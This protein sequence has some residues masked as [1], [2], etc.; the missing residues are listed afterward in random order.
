[1]SQDAVN[2]GQ[3]P[4]QDYI[5]RIAAMVAADLDL[6]TDAPDFGRYKE[7][8]ARALWYAGLH[9]DELMNLGVE[10]ESAPE[11]P[12][13]LAD[14]EWGSIVDL[15]ERQ[16]IAFYWENPRWPWFALS[17]EDWDLFCDLVLRTEPNGWSENDLG[18][19]GCHYEWPEEVSGGMVEVHLYL[20]TGELGFGIPT[21]DWDEFKQLVQKLSA[22][23]WARP[24]RD[25]VETDRRRAIRTRWVQ[26]NIK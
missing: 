16:V 26:E 15:P 25:T 11:D 17:Y 8:I 18:H 12:I 21:A 10:M 2:R 3:Q 22:Y 14:L 13:V 1:M 24:V 20:D 5:T 7:I 9:P 4:H 6:Q 23:P 19:T